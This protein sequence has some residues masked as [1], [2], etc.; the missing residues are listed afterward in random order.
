MP[1]GTLIQKIHCHEA[2]SVMAPPMT[3][4]SATPRPAI[5]PQMPSATPRFS[6]A[7]T[8]ASSVSVS[9]ITI[10]PPSPC[11][12]RAAISVSMSGAS[13]A[14]ALAAVKTSSPMPS[15]RR[16]PNRSPSAAPVSRKTANVSVYALTVHSRPSSPVPSSVRMTGSALVTIRL[17][18][19][20][21][22]TATPLH[23]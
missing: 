20:T 17:S 11:T 8:L 14:A 18:I 19:D 7:V 1:T 3:G 21:M 4:P 13:A 23:R 10:A 9:G 12:A 15:M 5:A 22:N 2:P 16:R 6:G